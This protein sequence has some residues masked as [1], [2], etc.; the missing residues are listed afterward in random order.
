M[1]ISAHPCAHCY[2]AAVDIKDEN[3]YDFMKD[4]RSGY[5]R[6]LAGGARRSL[7][8]GRWGTHGA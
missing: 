3:H 5:A 4:S 2:A 1:R 6:G 8:P 7:Q